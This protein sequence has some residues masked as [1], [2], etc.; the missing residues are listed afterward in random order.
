[1]TINIV[2]GQFWAV[3]G[4][5]G[6]GKSSLLEVVSGIAPLQEA[7]EGKICLEIADDNSQM[8]WRELSDL[9]LPTLSTSR[10]LVTQDYHS[11]FAIS[12]AELLHF[13]AGVPNNVFEFIQGEA[14]EKQT[15]GKD[16]LYQLEAHL[17]IATLMK[18]SFCKLSGGEKQRVHLARNLLQIG[19][20]I[21]KGQAL[22]LLDE[23]LQQLDVNYQHKA[24]A[25]FKLLQEKGNTL[26]MSHHDINQVQTYCSHA[27]LL[28]NGRIFKQ[29]KLNDVLSITALS[30]LY[31]HPFESIISQDGQSSYFVSACQ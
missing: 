22:V 6:A 21:E 30:E 27:C 10:C 7:G 23:P 29:G 1:M 11:E 16:F 26:V 5:N 15:S 3:M 12:V 28:K 4:P 14:Q 24:L 8:H 31:E 20:K 19:Q 2:R 18:R 25:L 17:N 9:D 13:F